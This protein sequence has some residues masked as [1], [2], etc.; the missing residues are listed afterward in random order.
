MLT[1]TGLRSFKPK[2]KAYKVTDGGGMHAAVSTTG[3]IS[4]R[5][6]YRLNGRRETLTIGRYDRRNG[7]PTRS[8]DELDYGMSVCLAEARILLSKA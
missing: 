1:D 2:D 3:V 5:Y 6:D 4:F 7:K 8:H